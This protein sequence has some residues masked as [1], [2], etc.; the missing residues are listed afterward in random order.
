MA[1]RAMTAMAPGVSSRDM[2]SFTSVRT[3]AATTTP[4]STTT[5]QYVS[6]RRRLDQFHESAQKRDDESGR[7][8]DPANWRVYSANLPLPDSRAPHPVAATP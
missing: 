2:A 6:Q 4:S 8:S 7:A 1:S 3:G 5:A